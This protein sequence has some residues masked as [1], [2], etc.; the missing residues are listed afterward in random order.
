MELG[1]RADPIASRL[2]GGSARLLAITVSSPS[3]NGFSVMQYEYFHLLLQGAAEEALSREYW[4]VLAPSGAS[5]SYHRMPLDGVIV[6]DPRVD[7]PVLRELASDDVPIVTAG[8]VPD[9]AGTGHWVDNDHYEGTLGLLDELAVQGASRIAL[10]NVPQ[11][12]SYSIDTTAA[13][14]AWCRKQGTAPVIATARS[15]LDE[16]TGYEVGRKLLARRERPDAIHAVLDELAI[17]VLSAA[18][19]L[20]IDVP[21]D[22]LVSG[23]TDTIRSRVSAPPLTV[24]DLHPREIGAQAASVLIDV[25]EERVSGPQNRV[26]ATTLLKRRSTG[27]R[28]T[29]RS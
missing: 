16:R 8:R 11:V 24:L 27:H 7:D 1:Y 4:P 19:E 26:V 9:S 12:Y 23:T 5:G 21:G 10:I 2:A 3:G 22:L 18:R 28:P 13:Y 25:V 17:G 6:V 20:E 29:R 15:G 14:D